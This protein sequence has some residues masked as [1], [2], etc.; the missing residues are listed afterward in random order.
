MIDP[1]LI[2]ALTTG[3]LGAG[4]CIGM[5]G[6]LIAALALSERN[7]QGGGI[8]FQLLYHAGRVLTY[9]LIGGAVGWL[10]S[11]FAY[12]DSFKD[13]TRVLLVA[14]DLFIILIGLGSAGLFSYLS[15]LDLEF[16]GPAKT[17]VA[18]V[19]RLISGHG[20]LTAFPLGALLGLLP[21]GYV[22]AMAIIAAQ[23]TSPLKGALLMCIFGLGTI[24]ALLFF[25][26]A[27]GWLST[28]SRTW[29][30]RGAGLTVAVMGGYNM[31]KHLKEI[32]VI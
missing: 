4:H 1:L 28:R 14:S 11:A 10:G 25:G 16:P 13:V 24:P 12:T 20:T 22:Y 19:R 7:Q 23:T 5:C 15:M 30:L 31:V 9:T 18:G 17:L 29:M 27:V 3:L 26:G 21:C 6:N 2:L 32:G 8:L